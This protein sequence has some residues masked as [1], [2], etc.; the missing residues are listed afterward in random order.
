MLRPK[1][2]SG[3]VRVPVGICGALLRL[4]GATPFCKAEVANKETAV[5]HQT[6]AI[7]VDRSCK[8][9]TLVACSTVHFI[10]MYML[11]AH[12][13]VMFDNAHQV[14]NTRKMSLSVCVC[15]PT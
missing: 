14:K 6:N 3:Y 1:C 7:V 10:V 5:P 2:F 12:C 8:G 4:E 11:G 9:R 13:C 15:M